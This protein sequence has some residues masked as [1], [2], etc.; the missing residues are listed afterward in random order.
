MKQKLCVIGEALIDF[1]PQRKGCDLKDVE[2]F[3][4][5]A[6]GAPANVAGAVAKLGVPAMVLTQL[7]KDAFGDHIIESLKESGIDTSH[8]LQTS[9][10][11]T[12]LSFVSLREDGNRDFKFYRRTAADLQYGP[13]NIHEH[14]LDDC[15]LVH[16]CSVSLVDS[17]MKQ[18]HRALLELALKKGV[19]ISFD[20]NLR[21]SLWDDAEALKQTVHEFLP[22]ADILKLSDEELEFIT[23]KNDIEEALPFLFSHR[24]KCVVYTQGKDGATL[25]RRNDHISA[26]GHQ[27]QVV[28]TTG[29]GDSF[30]GA[31]L[32]CLL[33]EESDD[34]E[35]I[36]LERMKHHLEFA[37]LYAAHTTTM[38]GALAAMA[39]QEQLREFQHALYD[40][41]DDSSLYL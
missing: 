32:Y 34:L 7:G 24:C 8:I 1:I 15:G 39:D 22:Y 23:G 21:F 10:Y 16:F 40:D 2:G 12:S 28:D 19:L 33:T 37:N 4:R 27:V 26:K 36:P 5:V 11:D 18:A 14:L 41:D 9:A 13:E 30:I 38:A 6:G 31:F 25:Y 20:P 29:A 35:A 17:P 3:S